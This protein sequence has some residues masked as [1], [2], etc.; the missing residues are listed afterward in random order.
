MAN[1]FHS[2][3]TRP[4]YHLFNSCRGLPDPLGDPGHWG[5]SKNST[6]DGLIVRQG[7][8]RLKRCLQN[9]IPLPTLYS[10]TF[11]NPFQYY[12]N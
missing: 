2:Q 9:N 4:R 12:L 6:A 1:F 5:V 11:F 8:C 7:V 10:V 3:V